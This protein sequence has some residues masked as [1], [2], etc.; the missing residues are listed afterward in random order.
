M[1]NISMVYQVELLKIGLERTYS[2]SWMSLLTRSF[3]L[4]S[5]KWL[6]GG[7]SLIR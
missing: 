4:L 5:K 3:N 6:Q 1:A 7:I 2:L